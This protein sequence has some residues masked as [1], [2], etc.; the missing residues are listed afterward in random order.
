VLYILTYFY[1][2]LR[3]QHEMTK[4]QGKTTTWTTMAK[5]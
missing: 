5:N 2:V 1:A 3:K 4:I